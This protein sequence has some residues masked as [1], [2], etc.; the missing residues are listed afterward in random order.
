MICAWKELLAILPPWLT[1][2][3]DKHGR[4][5]L[6]E[7]RLR[8]DQPP[9]L[10]NKD[11]VIWLSREVSMDDLNFCI[12]T[13]SRYSPWAAQSTAQGY[14]TAPG[15]HRIGLCGS[16]ISQVGTV[17]GI[18]TVRSLCIRIA[19]D[20]PGIACKYAGYKGSILIIGPPGSGKTTLLRDLIRQLSLKETVAVVDERCELFPDGCFTQGKSLDV[21]SGCP[22]RDG[23]TM[24]LRAMGP[25]TIAVDEI[26]DPEDSLSLLQAAHCGVR[27][28]ATAHAGS[29]SDFCSRDVY[30]SLWEKHIFDIIVVLRKDRTYTM[31]RVTEWVTNGSVQY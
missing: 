1:R 16:V 15:G 6:Q 29:V 11:G 8:L 10:I 9:Q 28:L 14:I 23:I 5:N 12:N 24:L 7:L 31:E 20:F 4:D 2:E 25:E 17:T 13:A 19:R 18:R 27:L 22:K 21:L 30:Q 3:V 26:T